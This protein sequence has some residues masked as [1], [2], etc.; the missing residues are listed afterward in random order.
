M[1]PARSPAD[2]TP[3]A[4]EPIVA[5]LHTHT[6]VSDGT[7]SIEA[8]PEAAREAGLTWVA[9]TDHDRIHPGIDAPVVNRDGVRLVRGI[10]LRVDAG[11]ERLDLLGYAVEHTP[12]LDAE[13]ARL[14]ADREE[15]GAAIVNRVEERLDVDLDVEVESGIGR[16]HIARAIADS[17]APYDYEAAFTDLIGDGCPCY[18]PR[19]VTGL[20]T[21][22]ELLREACAVVGL[23]HPFRYDDVGAALSVARDLDAVERWYPYGRPVDTDRVDR[24]VESASLLAA[25]GSDAHGQ[26]LGAAGLTESDFEPIRERLPEPR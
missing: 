7:L 14:Q 3:V 18:V 17:G 21:G 5:D 26:T 19:S 1:S 8:V 20:E 16:P 25:G 22:V 6:T 13:I 4:D 2:A 24:V 10:E 23:A 12:R 11:P 15:R 9:V